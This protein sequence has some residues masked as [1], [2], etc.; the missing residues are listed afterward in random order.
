ML[1]E[2]FDN[3]ICEALC[4]T[5]YRVL[6]LLII[7]VFAHYKT[8]YGFEG[9][10]DFVSEVYKL[11]IRTVLS[12]NDIIIKH[13]D[14]YTISLEPNFIYNISG[15]VINKNEFSFWT[16]DVTDYKAFY[17]GGISLIY[18]DNISN[19]LY[20]DITV[21]GF[22]FSCKS[23]DNCKLE[24]IKFIEIIVGDK[25]VLHKFL[26]LLPG[27]EVGVRGMDISE[28]TI[29]EPDGIIREYYAHDGFPILYIDKVSDIQIYRK[30]NR[31]YLYTFWS[32]IVLLCI[33]I[34]QR[35]FKPF[36]WQDL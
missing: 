12:Q 25:E 15:M 8:V 2:K 5:R 23:W 4:K 10:K 35:L 31:F 7:A 22:G 3:P 24:H 9:I 29:Y 19:E 33:C 13:I 26:S 17:P 21:D 34:V 27:D 32:A 36:I 30:V 11:P 18:A 14:N 28:F 16:G 1:R 20:N 6:L